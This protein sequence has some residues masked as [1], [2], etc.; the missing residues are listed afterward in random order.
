MHS[1]KMEKEALE[2]VNQSVYM[3][4]PYLRGI[5]P[6]VTAMEN[7]QFLLVYKGT[8][9]TAD[10]HSMPIALRVISD[11]DGSGLRISSSH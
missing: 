4:F 6:E 2:N 9:S 7:G 1:G 3:R 10:G 8:A 5:E 11:K